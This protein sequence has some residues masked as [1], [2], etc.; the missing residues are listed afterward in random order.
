EMRAEILQHAQT[1]IPPRIHDIGDSAISVEEA[2][3]INGADPA[4][5]QMISDTLNQCFVAV[6]VRGVPNHAACTSE[7]PEVGCL[8]GIGEQQRLLY[9]YVLSAL[10]EPLQQ[11][12]FRFIGRS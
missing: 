3:V 6:V 11:L 10:E 1:L 8:T 12:Q 9:E 5:P 7:I 4:G 2:R